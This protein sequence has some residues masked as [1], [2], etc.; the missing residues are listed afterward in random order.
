MYLNR[1]QLF[2]RDR[3][4]FLTYNMVKSTTSS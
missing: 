4:L 1:I 2:T 3:S